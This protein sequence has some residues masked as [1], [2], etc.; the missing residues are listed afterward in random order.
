[1]GINASTKHKGVAFH[2]LDLY[3]LHVS[4]RSVLNYLDQVGPNSAAV[5]RKRY[6]CLTP[7][8]GDPATYGHAALTGS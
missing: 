8:Q 3:S 5:A 2:G 7:W 1:V 4:I 6:G